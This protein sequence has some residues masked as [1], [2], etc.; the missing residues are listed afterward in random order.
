MLPLDDINFA[1]SDKSR[2]LHT[3]HSSP[4]EPMD[5]IIILHLHNEIREC[6]ESARTD[7]SGERGI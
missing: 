5:M 3:S 6:V 1:V 7:D 2:V 4:R